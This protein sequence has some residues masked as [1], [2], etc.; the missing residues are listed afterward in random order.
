MSSFLDLFR[1][2]CMKKREFWNKRS[3]IRKFDWRSSHCQRKGQLGFEEYDLRLSDRA[4]SSVSMLFMRLVTN[5]EFVGSEF[6]LLLILFLKERI[7]I[8][9]S[10]LVNLWLL[11]S[12]LRKL[13]SL[14]KVLQARIL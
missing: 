1:V 9:W 6:H 4:S 11:Q 10:S 12:S 3:I 2:S 7:A 5:R 8:R 13:I 14:G